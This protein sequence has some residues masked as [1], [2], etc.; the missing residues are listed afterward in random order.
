[1]KISPKLSAALVCLFFSLLTASVLAEPNLAKLGDAENGRNVYRSCA[2]CHQPEG[3]GSVDGSYPQIA[4]QLPVVTIK[5]MA[6]IRDRRRSAPIMLPFTQS[7]IVSDQEIADVAAYIAKLPMN[8]LNNTGSGSDLK[9]GEEI[10]RQRCAGCHGDNGQGNAENLIP[11]IQ[12]QNYPYLM[13]QFDEFRNGR[14]TNDGEQMRQHAKALHSEEISAVLD[15]VSR[16]QP[17]GNRL[18]EPGW[19]NSDF[20]LFVRNGP[21][22]DPGVCKTNE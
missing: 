11:L 21:P 14:R 15:Y 2:S 18:A 6:D 16:I 20:P 10:Y 19:R 5:Q 12:A 1:M 3:W 9:R 7:E 4:G 22:P 17:P 8:P 13:R